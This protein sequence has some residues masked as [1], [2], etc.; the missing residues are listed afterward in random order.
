[1]R[2]G[3]ANLGRRDQHTAEDFAFFGGPVEGVLHI[4]SRSDFSKLV[5]AETGKP[6]VRLI[7]VGKP[8]RSFSRKAIRIFLYPFV[9][10]TFSPFF[11]TLLVI[12]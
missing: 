11:L 1:L 7:R 12:D 8:R 10:L 9:A 3:Y 5:A 6:T 2:A 4:L